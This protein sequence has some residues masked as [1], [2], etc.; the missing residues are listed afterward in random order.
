M[1]GAKR[2][3]TSLDCIAVMLNVYVMYISICFM[4]IDRVKK[5]DAD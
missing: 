1:V 2:S 3:P 5:F 4:I